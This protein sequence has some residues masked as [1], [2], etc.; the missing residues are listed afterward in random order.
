MLHL[1]KSWQQLQVD[2]TKKK[3]KKGKYLQLEGKKR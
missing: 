2:F 3:K 1:G